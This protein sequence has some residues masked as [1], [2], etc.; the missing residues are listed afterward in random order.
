MYATP[1]QFAAQQQANAALALNA[2]HILIGG[3]E[4]LAHLNLATVRQMLGDGAKAARALSEVKGLQDLGAAGLAEPRV[5][6][7]VSYSRSIYEIAAETQADLN[8]LVEARFA[9]LNQDFM[10]QLEQASKSA[11]AGSEAA[12]AMFKTSVA[13]ANSAYDTLSKAAKQVA[14]ATEASVAQTAAAATGG[15]RKK[16]SKA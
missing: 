15:S 12:M 11:P 6:A 7:L 13:A 4:K 3:A 8:K 9:G 10:A 2:F 14:E 5:D 16:A 1:E